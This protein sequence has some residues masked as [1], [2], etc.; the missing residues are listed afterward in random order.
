MLTTVLVYG[1]TF[2]LTFPAKFARKYPFE[3]AGPKLSTDV[4]GSRF[5]L[6]SI[7]T[8]RSEKFDLHHLWCNLAH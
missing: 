4:G 2:P 1:V 5:P 8:F 7:V 3:F 6:P